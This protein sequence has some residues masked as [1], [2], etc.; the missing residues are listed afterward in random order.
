MSEQDIAPDSE[1]GGLY[2]DTVIGNYIQAEQLLQADTMTEL[3]LNYGI[4]IEENLIIDKRIETDNLRLRNIGDDGYVSI[5]ASPA[6]GVT[7]ELELPPSGPVNSNFL[8]YNGNRLEWIDFVAGNEITIGITNDQITISGTPTDKLADADEDTRICLEETSDEDTIRFYTQDIEIATLSITGFDIG[9]TN[10]LTIRDDGS[11]KP[12]PICDQD[13]QNNSLYFNKKQLVY[14]DPSGCVKNLYN[15]NQLLQIFLTKKNW[16]R[17]D[18]GGKLWGSSAY[19]ITNDVRYAPVKMCF[20]SKCSETSSV[21]TFTPVQTPGNCNLS[22]SSDVSD[23]SD[24]DDYNY[25]ECI[26]DDCSEI[27]ARKTIKCHDGSYTT[28]PFFNSECIFN[29]SGVLLSGTGWTTL[30]EKY[31]GNVVLNIENPTEE[32]CPTGTWVLS[33][34]DDSVNAGIFRSTHCPGTGNNQLL[35]RWLPNSPIEFRKTESGCD[36]V[37]TFNDVLSLTSNK[38]FDV[39]L[40][41][42]SWRTIS[43]RLPKYRL[44][45]M[46]SI[47]S[48]VIDSPSAIFALSKNK[49]SNS[50]GKTQLIASPSPNNKKLRI[51]WLPNSKIQIKKNTSNYDGLYTVVIH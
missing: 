37:Y 51:R 26:W 11:I 45:P 22:D 27:E 9:I 43:I 8:Y 40:T 14:K 21:S 2:M 16:A 29:D 36:G 23:N 34:R 24:N 25:I 28:K 39:Q 41:G 6:T 19:S 44:V 3:N 13:T 7:Y 1:S 47:T 20:L 5:F 50:A 17:I 32:D 42:T 10:K 48:D 49:A 35:I 30:Y 38:A 12:A 4:K 31:E 46:V 33:K 15:D 18:P